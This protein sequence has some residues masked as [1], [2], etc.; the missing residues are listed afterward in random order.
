MTHPTPPDRPP[1]PI[2]FDHVLWRR[3]PLVSFALGAVAAAA[4]AV[5]APETPWW[6]PLLA[7]CV[8]A[9]VAFRLL[10]PMHRQPGWED[11]L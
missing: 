8:V 6:M 3:A 4:V 2:V 7:F 1:E 11:E 9:A 5:F 10:R